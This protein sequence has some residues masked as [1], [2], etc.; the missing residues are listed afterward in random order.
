MKVGAIVLAVARDD[1]GDLAATMGVVGTL[2]AAW[3]TRR[4]G[5]IDAFIRPDLSFY[6]RFSGSPL[7]DASGR[8][9]GLNT[10]G[11]SR[12][13]SLAVP[14]Q[15][16][17]RVAEAIATRGHVARG[18]LG[19]AMQAIDIPDSLGAG[20][21]VMAL[22]VEPDGPAARGGLIIGDV[23]TTLRGRRIADSDDIQAL[24]DSASVGTHAVVGVLRGGKPHELTITIG[25]RP[26][27]D[28]DD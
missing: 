26:R 4:G 19:I 9:I 21:G 14:V 22:G 2:G 8:I 25:E 27:H 11:L 16:I 15:T 7:V 1:D 3:R 12:R 6:P 5:E 13:Q 20:S 10:A 24:L 17:A 28:H 18:Y 23:I